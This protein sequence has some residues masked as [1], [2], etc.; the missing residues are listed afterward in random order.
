MSINEHVVWFHFKH[1][2][3]TVL[4][5]LLFAWRL[6]NNRPARFI[7]WRAQSNSRPSTC[8]MFYIEQPARKWIKLESVTEIYFRNAQWNEKKKSKFN[9]VHKGDKYMSA[10]FPHTNN[11]AEAT[12]GG[13]SHKFLFAD[14]I[15]IMGACTVCKCIPV[16][17]WMMKY[18]WPE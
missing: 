8:Y 5:P 9:L 14:C 16:Y 4:R 2:D 11:S 13:E 1:V 10:K 12:L 17:A 7:L 15:I 6:L 3:G 18:H